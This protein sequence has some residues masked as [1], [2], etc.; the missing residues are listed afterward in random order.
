VNTID[1]IITLYDQQLK[2][3]GSRVQIPHFAL[4]KID[5]NPLTL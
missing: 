1:Q 2:I 5:L 4:F 3:E